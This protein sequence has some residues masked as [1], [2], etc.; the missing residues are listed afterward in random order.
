MSSDSIG[1][2]HFPDDFGKDWEALRNDG[3]LNEERLNRAYYKAWRDLVIVLCDFYMRR[4][5]ERCLVTHQEQN[6][7]PIPTTH[8]ARSVYN[9]D[10]NFNSS[11]MGAEEDFFSSNGI[12]P[13]EELMAF[14]VTQSRN[15]AQMRQMAR[16]NDYDLVIERIRKAFNLR[17]EEMNLLMPIALAAME[18]DVYRAMAIASGTST[19]KKFRASFICE[20]QGFTRESAEKNQELLSDRG[21][22]IRMHLVIPER[23]VGESGIVN[24][25]F[26]E[27]SVD[28]RVVDAIRNAD[29]SAN[30]PMHMHL[31]DNPQRPQSLYL[32]KDFT[33]QFKLV[34]TQ[35]KARILL[36]GDAHSGR[37]TA[38]C[39]YA[40]S[41][42]H[43]RVLEIDFI[44]EMENL[45]D[46]DVNDRFCDCLREALLLD[47]V[48]LIRFDGIFAKTFNESRMNAFIA[49][50]TRHISYYPG[51]IVITALRSH[52][53][54]M[55]LFEEPIECHIPLP[56]PQQQEKV[57][58]EA[59]TGIFDDREMHRIA[60]SFSI[61]YHL[62]V[63]EILRTVQR[64]LDAH[65]IRSEANRSAKLE[66]HHILEEIRQCFSHE[67]DTLADVVLSSTPLERVI[68]PEETAKTV[69]DIMDFARYQH[70]VLDE[71]GYRKCSAYGNS[72]SILFAGP[73]GTGKTLLATAMAHELGKILYR[74]DLS[75]I[76]DKYVGET[77]KNLGKI[78]DEAAKAQAILLFDEA[79]SLF[80]KR[81]D[82]KSSNDRYAN[83]EVNFLIQKLESYNGISILTTN[84]QKSIDEAF[85]RRLRFI[86]EFKE[87]D[88]AARTQLWKH[89]VPPNAPLAPDIDWELL[90]DGFELSGG[91][92]RNA[93]LNAS[94]RA[95]ASGEP[96]GMRFLLEGAIAETKKLG[97]LIKLNEEVTA[98]LQKY[99]VEM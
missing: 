91:Y 88:L 32:S 30:M 92:I 65:A 55:K 34:L 80:A 83:L 49:P 21:Q 45:A 78:F 67:L 9:D 97:K 12:P 26:A 64:S 85:K 24:R 5:P 70:K 95:A 23:A 35:P 72:L 96:L 69:K 77:E 66:S 62:T 40:K 28:Q 16:D 68:L 42:L 19:S 37:R 82:V 17:H 54:I 11:Y 89:L 25:L 3:S 94:I 41:V 27:L 74:V 81:T 10:M 44:A 98:I 15:M 76:V 31:H 33:R 39:T 73:P 29:L 57:W 56:S 60:S 1:V 13:Y 87:P 84:L 90:S 2:F 14:M 86:V 52:P 79:D 59:L 38:T 47:T 7:R 50:L 6:E 36:T 43:K 58:T 75:R 18:N 22:L 8:L 93:T 63:G 51:V 4:F 48:L 71:W 53:I 46:E 61:N 20:L 99:G